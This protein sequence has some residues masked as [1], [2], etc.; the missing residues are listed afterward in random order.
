MSKCKHDRLMAIREIIATRD[1]SGQDEILVELSKRGFSLTQATLSRDIK[2]MQIA[3]VPDGMGNYRYRLAPNTVSRQMNSDE[4]VHNG[5]DV[6]SNCAVSLEFSGQIAVLK[7]RP[8][9]ASVVADMIDKGQS[10]AIM[11]TLAGDDTVLLIIREHVRQVD[12][13]KTLSQWLTN[14]ENKVLHA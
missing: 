10:G 14:I 2:E 4:F 3:K 9:Y 11:G 1:I 5:V 13:V 6:I 7:T 8:G 12:V